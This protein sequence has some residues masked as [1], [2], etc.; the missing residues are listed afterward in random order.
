MR[1][2]VYIVY[3]AFGDWI[4]CNGMIRHLTKDYDKILLVLDTDGCK[5][6]VSH[7]FRD[8]DK[9]GVIS[10]LE[11]RNMCMSNNEFDVIDVRVNEVYSH[12]GNIGNYY[13][14]D[15]KYGSY[16][17]KTITDNASGFYVHSG[18]SPTIRIEEFDYERD[19]EEEKR[20]TDNINPPKEYAVICEMETGMIDRSYIHTE[21][22]LNLHRLTENFTDL[23]S[24]IE[25]AKE[26][27]LIENSIG[28]FV[29]HLQSSGLMESTPINL[30]SYARQESHRKCE[31]EDC[32]NKFLNMLKYPKL[33]NW[34]FIWK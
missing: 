15:S 21:H 13:S 24:I 32:N 30:H 2:L 8:S 11:Y 28:L 3:D 25:N 29:Y 27:H 4:S 23:I 33:Y 34:N 31:G 22:I 19:L 9:I 18:F 5:S 10:L 17:G 1:T 14:K 12:P 7:M 16:S 26:V 20:I 6:F